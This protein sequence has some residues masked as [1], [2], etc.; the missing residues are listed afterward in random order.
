MAERLDLT[1]AGLPAMSLPLSG[2]AIGATGLPQT[3]ALLLIVANSAITT[4]WLWPA[5][6]ARAAKARLLDHEVTRQIQLSSGS[7]ATP[8]EREHNRR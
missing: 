2:A 1:S 5:W 8:S 7:P 4:W 6:R 3:V